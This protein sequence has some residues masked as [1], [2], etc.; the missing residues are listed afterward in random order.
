MISLE[1]I[2]LYLHFIL[3]KLY[4]PFGPLVFAC[5]LF[6]EDILFR[7]VL[8]MDDEKTYIVH[9]LSHK[10]FRMSYIMALV[11]TFVSGVHLQSCVALLMCYQLYSLYDVAHTTQ[12]LIT[13]GYLFVFVV[14]G[15]THTILFTQLSLLYWIFM[16]YICS[17][18][19][20][21]RMYVCRLCVYTLI[22]MYNNY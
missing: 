6:L 8:L 3:C 21:P 7:D 19:K 13:G 18:T 10:Q 4:H 1:I 17:D 5:K 22:V 20:I 16:N 11:F 14:I 2:L 9:A 12:Y 15:H